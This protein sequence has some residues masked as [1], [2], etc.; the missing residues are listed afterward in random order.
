MG[1]IWMLSLFLWAIGFNTVFAALDPEELEEIKQAAPLHFVG[2]VTQDDFL[3]EIDFP[4]QERVMSVRVDEVMKGSEW[5]R[6][7]EE[8]KVYYTYIP[9]WVVMEGG[10]KMD[11]AVSD[12]IEIW[13]TQENGNWQPASSGD[14]VSHLYKNE[15]RP[16]HMAQP[17]PEAAAGFWTKIPLLVY[18]I[19]TLAVSFG[20]IA[21]IFA[22]VPANK[23]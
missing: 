5:V 14:T 22:R 9:Q 1:R 21:L 18:V 17:F 8:I 11:I 6:P 15:E 19:F 20:L 23:R 4:G 7:G 10:A 3:K 13:L 16:E 12:K 2:E